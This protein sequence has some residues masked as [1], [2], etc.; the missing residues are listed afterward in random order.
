M[1]IIPL[2]HVICGKMRLHAGNKLEFIFSLGSVALST[3]TLI[4][5]ALVFSG[6]TSP[7]APQDL[8]FMKVSV[9]LNI[10]SS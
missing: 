3:G 2:P 8:H 4:C 9:H 1:T 10:N 5:L 7:S 6:C